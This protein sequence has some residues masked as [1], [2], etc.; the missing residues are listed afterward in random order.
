MHRIIVQI[1]KARTPSN[2]NGVLCLCDDGTLW[3]TGGEI[4]FGEYQYV[5]T[6]GV[7]PG[8]TLLEL[9]IKEST[10]KHFNGQVPPNPNL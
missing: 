7:N 10:K 4:G 8:F 5:S 1:A 3:L 9:E 6:K 2:E